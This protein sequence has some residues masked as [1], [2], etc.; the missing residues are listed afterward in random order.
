VIKGVSQWI[1]EKHF[2]SDD[3]VLDDEGEQVDRAVFDGVAND[4]EVLAIWDQCYD[5]KNIFAK[6]FSGNIFFA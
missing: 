6:K 1:P 3:G 5:F 2:A 4:L